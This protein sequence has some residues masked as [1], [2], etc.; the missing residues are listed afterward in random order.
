MMLSMCEIF[1]AVYQMSAHYI[2]CASE[3]APSFVASSLVT[4]WSE[5]SVVLVNSIAER[6]VLAKVR[7]R[8][9]LESSTEMDKSETKQF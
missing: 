8:M 4:A 9:P 2:S 1:N 3:F 5:V 6:V 7:G